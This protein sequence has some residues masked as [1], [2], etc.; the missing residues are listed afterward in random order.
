MGHHDAM[1]PAQQPASTPDHEDVPAGTAGSGTPT[2][3]S[4]ADLGWVVC[5]A[6]A[7]AAVLALA[8]DAFVNSNEPRFRGKGMRLR[9]VGY[10]GTMLLVP[11]VWRIRGRHAPYPRELD[12]AITLPLLAD[13]GGNAVGI[14]QRAHVDDAIHFANGALLAS[15]VGTLAS[16]RVR[17]PWEAFGVAASVGTAAAAGWE[18]LEWI[19]LKLGAR[20][21]H[22]TYDDTMQDLIETSAG[23]VLGGIVALLRHPARLRQIPGGEG[24]PVVAERPN[25]APR[26][27]Q[28]AAR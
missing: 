6:A 11:I 14:Y 25:S 23:A 8:V 28:A 27:G 18:I 24:D 10:T 13:A 5:I 21:M 1:T 9:A 20:G 7:K 2:L 22:L 12:L 16:P 15:V 19:G 17:T 3:P 4:A 26:H